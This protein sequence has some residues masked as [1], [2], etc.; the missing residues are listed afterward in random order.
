[1][2]GGTPFTLRGFTDHEH[3]DQAQLIHMNGRVY[4]YNLGRFLSIDPLIQ[5]PGNSQSLNPYSYIMNN[6]LAG[7]DPSGYALVQ[8]SI[9][10]IESMAACAT[11]LNGGTP[12]KNDFSG[13]AASNGSAPSSD[14]SDSDVEA[15]EVGAPGE[16]GTSGK[17]PLADQS[18]GAK[19]GVVA[20]AI[21]L[22][23]G[24]IVEDAA[25]LTGDVIA[26]ALA[27]SELPETAEEYAA[28]AERGNEIIRIGHAGKGNELSYAEAWYIYKNAPKGFELTVD[29]RVIGDIGGKMATPFP[30]DSLK[31]HGHVS[32]D[33]QGRIKPSMYDFAPVVMPNPNN[34]LR[35][36]IRNELNQIAIKQHGAGNPYLIK[37]SYDDKDFK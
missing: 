10:C 16:V 26:T 8:G 29:G 33:S 14:G 6:P 11:V 18:F 25:F 36:Y 9:D 4:D 24:E 21:M 20:E 32:L 28:L 34:S 37:Y 2:A 12:T 19:L 30:L 35:I 7:T 23:G 5:A 13:A 15:E 22:Y 1:M 27:G 3:I 17:T 31:V